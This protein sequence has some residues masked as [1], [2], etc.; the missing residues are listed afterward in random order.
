MTTLD[1]AIQCVQ[2]LVYLRLR[3]AIG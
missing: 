1:F 2:V 3:F